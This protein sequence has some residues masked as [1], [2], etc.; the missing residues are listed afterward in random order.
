MSEPLT[1]CKRACCYTFEVEDELL[2]SLRQEYA[3]AL[4]CLQQLQAELEDNVRRALSKRLIQVH[5]RIKTWESV[6][7]AATRFGV[8]SISQLQ[9]LIG[10]RVIATSDR[11][12]DHIADALQREFDCVSRSVAYQGPASMAHI[13]LLADVRSGGSTLPAKLPVDVRIGTEAS[14][15]LYQL[16]HELVYEREQKVAAAHDIGRARMV[17]LRQ[18]IREFERLLDRPDVHEKRHVHPFLARHQFLLTSSADTVLSEVPIG[19]GTQHRIDFVLRRPDAT[20]VLVEL[21][22][23]RHRLT[24]KAGDFTKEVNHALCQVE[25]WQDWI[26]AQQSLVQRHYPGMVSPEAIV[27]IGRSKDLLNAAKKRMARRNINMR[28]AVAIK[29]YDELIAGAEAFVASLEKLLP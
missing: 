5:T 25:D 8:Q 22:N 19:M 13:V 9:D 14:E 18:I 15:A 26:A 3:L 6:A 21:E 29:T 11:S 20:Y 16:A 7:E 27:I 1:G 28:G 12:L 2:S 24:N 10:V 23:P 4:P 17:E